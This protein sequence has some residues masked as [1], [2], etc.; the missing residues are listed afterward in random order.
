VTSRAGGGIVRAVR[1]ALKGALHPAIAPLAI[2]ACRARARGCTTTA[3]AFDLAERFEFLR[4]R[5][6]PMQVR[7]EFARLLEMLAARPPRALLEIG[8]ADGG[9]LFLYSRVAADDA[10][11]VSVDLPGGRFGGGY[12]AWRERLYRSFGRA[13]QRVE[14][15]RAD[16]HDPATRARVERLLGGRA[17]DFLFIDGD[18]SGAGVRADYETY[19]PLVRPGGIVAFHDI[20]PGPDEAVG[21]VPEF[22]RTLRRSVAAN[23]IVADWKQGGYGIGWFTVEGAD[24]SASPRPAPSIPDEACSPSTAKSS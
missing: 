22:W 4:V 2:R 15:L 17:L 6:A 1:R 7:A 14:L 12:P 8:T 21:G 20:V 3:E 24:A 23:E 5:I 11:L 18:H 13:R 9:T 19:A 10:L 16:S